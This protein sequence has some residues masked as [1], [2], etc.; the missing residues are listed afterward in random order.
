MNYLDII[1][2]TILIIFGIMGLIK[3]VINE[4]ASLVALIIGLYGMFYFSDITASW[5]KNI[6]DIKPEYIA[7]ISFLLTFMILVLVIVLL[8]KLL[9]KIV[10]SLSLG[11]LD[12]MG[13]LV[14]GILK[15]A[16]ITSLII[17]LLNV[18]NISGNIPQ[19]DRDESFLY[20]PVENTAPYL[21]NNSKFVRS[22]VEKS[23]ELFE[24]DKKDADSQNE[25]KKPNNNIV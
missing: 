1:I 9:S 17:L 25:D 22:A 14:F 11:W 18:L 4:V 19:K 15:G 21:Y 23:K 5:L 12:K 8:G 2:G 6:I 10:K 7:T 20:K 16:L 13:G 3:G 24:K